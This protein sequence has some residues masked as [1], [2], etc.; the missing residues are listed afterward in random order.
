MTGWV[1]ETIHR[2]LQLTR[3][4]TRDDG[5]DAGMDVDG[6]D[7]TFQVLIRCSFGT[8]KFSTKVRG[9]T[10]RTP[11]LAL[12]GMVYDEGGCSSSWTIMGRRSRNAKRA[13]R[14]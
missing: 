7:E 11:C 12:V 6:G 14:S 5:E 9:V 1:R 3:A 2:A 13:V 10:G 8:D 4:D